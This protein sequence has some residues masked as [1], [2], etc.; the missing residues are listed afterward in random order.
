[1]PDGQTNIAYPEYAT[2]VQ[3]IGDDS[4]MVEAHLGCCL[5]P[6]RSSL[7]IQR[8]HMLP[9]HAKKLPARCWR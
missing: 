3:D 8:L 9:L 7:F 4:V 2:V 5:E 6:G 1:M